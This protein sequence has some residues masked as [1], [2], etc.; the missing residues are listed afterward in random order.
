MIT[1]RVNKRELEIEYCPTEEVLADYFTKPVQG[2][3]FRKFRNAIL[4]ITD[5]N[6]LRYKGDY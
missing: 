4:G 6:Y 1:D 5:A 2:A 3:L